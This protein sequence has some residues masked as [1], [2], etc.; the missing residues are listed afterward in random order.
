VAGLSLRF[1]RDV[2][3]SEA[4]PR[5]PGPSNRAL[6]PAARGSG[7]GPRAILVFKL[8]STPEAIWRDGAPVT[9]RVG[10]GPPREPRAA[11]GCE[12]CAGRRSRM[13][14][15]TFHQG[16]RAPAIYAAS[17]SFEERLWGRPREGGRGP[18]TASSTARH[19]AKADHPLR[20]GR[21]GLAVRG[22]PDDFPL[23][24]RPAATAT[25][26]ASPASGQ[27]GPDRE[28]QRRHR[29]GT[30]DGPE[31][32]S[33]RALTGRL[34]RIP[35]VCKARPDAL[36]RGFRPQGT[37]TFAVNDRRVGPVSA[38]PQATQLGQAEKQDV[39]RGNGQRNASMP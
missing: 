3:R 1:R 30:R 15:R 10:D 9:S 28:R 13:P 7:A 35:C 39:R 20:Q 5:S 25:D 2:A 21:Q 6:L 26:R 17:L 22:S 32:D 29:L 34:P 27:G 18:P 33:G 8:R 37:E 12:C 14:R 24:P 19:A 36:K 23:Q 11:V 31:W 38:A 16:G 4:I